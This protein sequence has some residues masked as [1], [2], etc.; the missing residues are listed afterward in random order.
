MEFR[1]MSKTPRLSREIV[2]TEKLDGTNASV[3]VE[4]LDE[5][6]VAAFAG[7]PYRI[8]GRDYLVV[9][10][11]RT[12]W[13][14]R[15]DDNFG[16]AAWVDDHAGELVKLGPGHHFGEW[17]GKGIQRG[18]G[19]DERRFS[20]FNVGGWSVDQIHDATILACPPC[21][22]VVPVI[23]RGEFNLDAVGTAL[24]RLHDYGSLAA[25]G[26]MDPEG[27]MV[28]HTAANQLFKKT[29]EGDEEGK[30][31]E[32]HP[33]KDR[34]PKAPRDPSVGGRRRGAA[35]QYAGPWRRKTDA[36]DDIGTRS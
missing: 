8:D 1:P 25:P 4:E 31:A 33:K 16:F 29:L 22:C 26:F 18:Y 27:V 20:L 2:I 7:T 11:S 34:P 12:R 5:F 23:Y 13:I 10:G 30:H 36:L 19:L 14:C 6:G 9:A 17:W 35:E 28:Y 32:A 15:S 24:A 21:C 3:Y